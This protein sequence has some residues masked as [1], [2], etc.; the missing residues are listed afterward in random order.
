PTYLC[1][2][3]CELLIAYCVLRVALITRHAIRNTRLHY[4][5]LPSSGAVVGPSVLDPLPGS[6]GLA[7]VPI[8]GSSPGPHPACP[9]LP[10]SKVKSVELTTSVLSKSALASYPIW[11]TDLPNVT[12]N[13]VKSVAFTTLKLVPPVVTASPALIRPD[14]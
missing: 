12:F 3:L 8:P 6:S 11:P 5:L 2:I 1:V 9:K 4:L 14:S 13:V 7:P 10:L